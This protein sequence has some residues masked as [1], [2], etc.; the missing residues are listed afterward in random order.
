MLSGKR[1]MCGVANMA[2]LA[3]GSVSVCSAQTVRN[4]RI[5]LHPVKGQIG[6]A[7]RVAGNTAW[8]RF[9][10]RVA[11]GAKVEFSP[12]SDSG[13]TLAVGTVQWVA[14]VAPFEAYV[15]RIEATK[16]S[17]QLNEIE[18]RWSIAYVTNARRDYGPIPI[19]SSFGMV[20]A[21]GFFVRANV[22]APRENADTLEPVRAHIAALRARRNKTAD[23]IATAA[24]RALSRDSVAS[25]EEEPDPVNFSA[26]SDNL[27]RFRR[28]RIEDPVTARLLHRLFGY[29]DYHGTISEKVSTDFLRPADESLS[30][31]TGGQSGGTRR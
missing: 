11:E 12:Y 24:E 14:P 21:A 5:E 26:L 13:D 2:L 8:V 20:L 28:L 9:P 19:T 27:R 23:S 22:E 10:L 17:H 31:S 6:V 7:T 30:T 4:F 16:T 29:I 15:T 1:W 25:G 3:L 18:D